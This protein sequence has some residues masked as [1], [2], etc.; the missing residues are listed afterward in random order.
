ML[1]SFE[2]IHGIHIIVCACVYVC[3]RAFFVLFCVC[4][5]LF[6]Y[7]WEHAN[8]AERNF[9]VTAGGAY[10]LCDTAAK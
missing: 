9:L 2:S 8:N 4:V 6:F 3:V 10:R 5:F 7:V 1:F